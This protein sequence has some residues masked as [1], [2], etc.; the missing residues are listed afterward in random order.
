MNG[1]ISQT[2]NWIT[3]PQYSEEGSPSTWA[4]GLVLVLI[5]SFLWTMVIRQ[6]REV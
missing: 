5:L 2:L 4:A 6:I 3:H 1:L